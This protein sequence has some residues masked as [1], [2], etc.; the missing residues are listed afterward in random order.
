M[1]DTFELLMAAYPAA[2]AA[3]KDFDALS[4]AVADKSVK[5]EGIILVEHAEGGLGL[6]EEIDDLA[7]LRRPFAEALAR[8]FARV[9]RFLGVTATDVAAISKPLLRE[10]AAVVTAA[11]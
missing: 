5:T 4:A 2:D 1:S 8:G 6:L 9:A 11:C 10:R 3:A 7:R